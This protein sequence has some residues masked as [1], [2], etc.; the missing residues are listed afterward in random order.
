MIHNYI[1]LLLRAY[2]EK[3]RAIGL[4]LQSGM[5]LLTVMKMKQVS[6]ILLC[7]YYYYYYRS[8]GYEFIH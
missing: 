7:Y 5:D 4:T 1:T 3:V 6:C 8:I 2:I